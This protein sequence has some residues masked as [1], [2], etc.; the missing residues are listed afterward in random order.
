MIEQKNDIVYL[1]VDHWKY[2]DWLKQPER[3][4]IGRGRISNNRFEY[5]THPFPIHQRTKFPHN[6][7]TNRS[8][9]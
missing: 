2:L 7:K 8:R 1:L 3:E 6:E 5:L 4:P 9:N